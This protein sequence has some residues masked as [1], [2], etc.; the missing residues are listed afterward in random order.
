VY[1]A[2]IRYP[3][4]NNTVPVPNY[5]AALGIGVIGFMLGDYWGDHYRDRTWYPQRERFV[6]RPS[7][8]PRFN[9]TPPP[10][11]QA[12]RPDRGA[13]PGASRPSRPNERPPQGAAPAPRNPQGPHDNAP[14]RPRP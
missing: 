10:R 13:G 4:Q 14:D 11:Q 12:A 5:G 1:A 7:Y 3:Y 8:T 9:R 2:H 6:N